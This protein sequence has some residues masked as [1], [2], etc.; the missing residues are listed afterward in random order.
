MPFLSKGIIQNSIDYL[1]YHFTRFASSRVVSWCCDWLFCRQLQFIYCCWY[2]QFSD[3]HKIALDNE[4]IR[5]NKHSLQLGPDYNF[6][7]LG[8][9]T[10]WGPSD[11]LK[12]KREYNKISTLGQRR[13]VQV[14]HRKNGMDIMLFKKKK[15]KFL[16]YYIY[17]SRLRKFKIQ[18]FALSNSLMTNVSITSVN[19]KFVRLDTL[20]HYYK[21]LTCYMYVDDKVQSSTKCLG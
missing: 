5:N 12:K 8:L 7:G 10:M 18:T 15:N 19:C 17:L 6:V 2:L 13:W 11:N 16:K 14:Y 9:K 3:S 20:T 4:P 21:T 1:R